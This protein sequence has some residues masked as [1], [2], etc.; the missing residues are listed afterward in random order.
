[1]RFP[2]PAA[3]LAAAAWL[4]CAAPPAPAGPSVTLHG[5]WMKPN[6]ADADRYARES[7]GGGLQLVWPVAATQNLIAGVVGL[8]VVNLL[9]ERYEYRQTELP[10]LRII[11]S[12]NQNYGRLYVGPR[13]GL[14]GGEILRP[15]LG[16]N[17]GV[18]WYGIST[19]IEVPDDYDYENS[20]RQNLRREDHAVFGWDGTLGLE[21]RFTE[22]F[23]ADG[24]VRYVKSFNVPQQLGEGSVE[25]SPEYAQGYLG[26]TVFLDPFL[27]GR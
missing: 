4:A 9:N 10:F 26:F 22:R 8:E 18:N 17:V 2:Y 6:G 5:T 25:V 19:D 24:G 7:W 11:Q 1:M 27:H 13:V 15:H 21:I 12:T 16:V 14:H 3:A 23:G 20:L